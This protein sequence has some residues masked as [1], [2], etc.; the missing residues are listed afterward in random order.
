MET[1]LVAQ[2]R[3]IHCSQSSQRREQGF[4]PWAGKILHAEGNSAPVPQLLSPC[5]RVHEL[6]LLKPMHLQLVPCNKRSHC[7]KPVPP[8]E[9]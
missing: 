5:S 2:W 4:N 7:K 8:Y 9:G 6:R 1:S 3:R